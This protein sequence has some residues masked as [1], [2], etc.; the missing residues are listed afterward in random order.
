MERSRGRP[1]NFDPKVA[2]RIVSKTFRVGGFAATSLD[3]IAL[4]TGLQRPSLYAAFGDKK[5]MYL[6]SLQLLRDDI[7]AM[8]DEID[9]LGDDLRIKLARLFQLSINSYLSGESGPQGCLAICTASAEAA[10]DADIRS[11]LDGIL[12]LIDARVAKWFEQAGCES[13]AGYA[14]IISAAMH[15]ISVRA[16]AGQPREVLEQ[17]AADAVHLTV[18]SN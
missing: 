15:S 12:K 7:D 11:S 14:R 5:S 4:K 2:L 17:M 6:G 18:S 16:R 1:R 10:N 9:T 8:V 13:S 3:D